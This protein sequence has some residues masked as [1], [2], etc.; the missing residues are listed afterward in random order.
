MS[1]TFPLL[2]ELFGLTGEVAA[3]VGG[4]GRIGKVICETLASVGCKVAILDMEI[5]A[6]EKL[7]QQLNRQGFSTI[8]LES[9]TK[10]KESLEQAIET[11]QQT[12]GPPTI[13]VHATQYRGQGFY[14]S[15]VHDYPQAAWEEVLDTNLTGPFVACQVFGKSMSEHGGGSMVLF[16]STYGLVSP[17]P[18]IYGESG[19]NS[20]PAYAASKSALL[21]LTRYLA[22]HYRDK[23]IR[24]NCLC[25]GGVFDNQ[26]ESFV[27]A[28][29]E[30]TPLGRMAQAKDYCGAVLFLV[31]PSAAY[32]TGSILTIDGGWT[33]W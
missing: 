3:V 30:R 18:R 33:A 17:D 28:Y 24:V 10:S 11:I 29:C 22:V 12:W 19:V 8:A 16:G 4:A 14:S 26:E 23:N 6:A 2:D 27:K 13:L 21:N 5:E 25:P 32:M 31:S 15:E 1:A 9:D 20:P 7:S